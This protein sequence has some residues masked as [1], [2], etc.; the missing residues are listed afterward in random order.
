M[1]ESESYARIKHFL[2]ETW[3]HVDGLFIS[4][5]VIHNNTYTN[6]HNHKIQD[7]TNNKEMWA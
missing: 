6:M 1:V 5:S 7:H 2:S 3:L 4:D